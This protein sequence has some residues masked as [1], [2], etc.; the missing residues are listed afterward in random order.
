VNDTVTS[1]RL[2]TI[3]LLSPAH[4]G[5]R[6]G[7]QLLSPAAGFPLAVRLRESGATIGEIFEFMSGLYFRGKLAY[8]AAF[9]RAARHQAGALVITPGHGL[10]PPGRP[11]SHGHLAEIA[12]IPVSLDEPRYREPFERDASILA[13]GLDPDGIVVLLGSIATD[14]YVAVLEPALKGRLY[15]PSEFVGRGDMSRGGLMLRC[16]RERSELSYVPLQGTLRHGNR[17]PRLPALR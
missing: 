4:C 13:R 12:S 8:A 9:Q 10:L 1:A 5:G 7:Q 16:V 14:K 6:R 15:F 17:P 11:L 2:Q 3:F